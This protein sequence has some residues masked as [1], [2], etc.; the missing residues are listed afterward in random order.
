MSLSLPSSFCLPSQHRHVT[1]QPH[2]IIREDER[3]PEAKLQS[4]DVGQLGISPAP[5]GS[6]LNYSFSIYR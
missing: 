2:A 3:A 4:V 1:V 5:Q 6:V